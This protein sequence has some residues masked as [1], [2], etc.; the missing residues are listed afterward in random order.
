MLLL[1]GM[2]RG[3]REGEEELAPAEGGWTID[4]RRRRPGGVF[5]LAA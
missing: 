2:R 4:G 5:H 1:P 3:R